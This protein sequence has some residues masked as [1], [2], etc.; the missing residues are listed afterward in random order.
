MRRSLESLRLLAAQLADVQREARALG[1]FVGDR[2]L[3][4]CPRCCLMED[5]S[6]TGLLITSRSSALGEDTGLRFEEIKTGKF[7]CPKCGVIVTETPGKPD[8][9]TKRAKRKPRK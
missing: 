7:R 8:S 6:F 5:V 2:E 4:A 3:V 1:M 9:K